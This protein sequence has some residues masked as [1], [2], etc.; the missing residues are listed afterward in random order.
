MVR[1]VTPGYLAASGSA[2]RAGR[3]FADD[4]RVLVAAVS[5][6]L[7]RRLWPGDSLSAV[8]GRTLRQGG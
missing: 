2:L 3:F 4:E 1:S 5:E 7:A 6:S 8:V